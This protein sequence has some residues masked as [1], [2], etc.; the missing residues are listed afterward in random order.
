MLN[1]VPGRWITCKMGLRQG[2]PLSPYLFIIVA[3]VLQNVIQRASAKGDLKHPFVDS[4]PC[5]VLQYVDDTLILLRGDVSSIASLKT[6]LDSFSQATGL[7]I[8]FHKS[9]FVPCTFHMQTPKGWP[10]FWDVPSTP[11]LKPTLASPFLP[12]RFGFQIT[13]LC[14]QD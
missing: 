5:P 3:D 13:N 14:K 4:L 6:V 9:T 11:S 1:G 10:V 12:T 2:D 8:N 7:E